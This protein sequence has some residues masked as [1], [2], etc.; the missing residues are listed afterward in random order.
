MSE[1]LR[2]VG[3]GAVIVAATF[4]WLSARATRTPVSSPDRLIAE[5]RV[6]QIGSL[7][8]VLVAGAY[9]GFAAAAPSRLGV[10]TDVVL[11]LGFLVV[12]ATVLTRDP[13]EGLTI[14]ALAF[15][16]HALMDVL[17][18]PG[19]LPGDI[20]PRWYGVGC[21]WLNVYLGALSYLPLLKR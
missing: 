2:T 13:R 20:V 17:H 8:L 1:A 6:M 10:G 19:L 18:R 9:L 12:A 11:A 14:L 16:A 15:A 7:L 5:F 21:A 3:V 4:G